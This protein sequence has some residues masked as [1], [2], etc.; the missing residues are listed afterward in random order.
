MRRR[1]LLLLS[2]L[3][4][5]LTLSAASHAQI[6]TYAGKQESGHNY[7]IFLNVKWSNGVG[8]NDNWS[9]AISCCYPNW[10]PAMGAECVVQKDRNGRLFVDLYYTR[11]V[12]T[13]NISIRDRTGR[14]IWTGP[15]RL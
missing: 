2:S 10:S 11:E 6:A 9:G 12:S 4:F 13:L 3:L 15:F 14:T 1:L 8:C 7:R 5:V